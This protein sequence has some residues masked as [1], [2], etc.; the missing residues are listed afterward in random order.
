MQE[1]D[2][3][4]DRRE[5]MHQLAAI[6]RPSASDGERRA[7]EWIAER[8]HEFGCDAHVERERAHGGYWWPLGLPSAVAGLSGL[9]LRRRPLGRMRRLGAGL[10][11][12]L[13]AAALWDE[14][15]G[16][17]LRFRR[18]CLTHR[19]TWNVVAEGGDR[20]S[21]RTVVLVAHHDAAHSG[22]V[23]HPAL[24]SPTALALPGWRGREARVLPLL[25]GV[26]IAPMVV[27][28][29]AALG[30]RALVTA[31]SVMA[32][33]VTAVLTDI[34]FRGAVPGANDN[35]SGVITLLGVARKLGANE[36]KGVRVVFLSTGSEESFLEGM[37]GFAERHF[38]TLPKESTAF[39]NVDVVGSPSLQLLEGD[40]MVRRRDYPIEMRQALAAAASE[41]GVPLGRGLRVPAAWDSYIP[42]RA[43]YRVATLT[44]VDETTRS[45]PNYHW[46]SDTPDH[47]DW[48]TIDQ[49]IRVCDAFVRRTGSAFHR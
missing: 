3:E 48:R 29:G 27:A 24:P 32:A 15:D 30:R 37:R 2:I 22:L 45:F 14:L 36:P 46:P 5:W 18:W 10:V 31:G 38:S 26:L 16:V 43:G 49:A 17:G 11:C 21:E 20:G 9:W 4:R 34:G 13:A 42:L 1:M 44:S 47:L 12:L 6:E 7:A 28:A 8:L 23:F 41:A 39:I 40:G 19:S 33:G 35:L 25:A